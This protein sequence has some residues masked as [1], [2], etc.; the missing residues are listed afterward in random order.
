M[1][2]AEKTQETRTIRPWYRRDPWYDYL[3][4]PL[5]RLETDFESV[6]ERLFGGDK[7]HAPPWSGFVPVANLVE[8]E[9]QYEVAIELPGMQP[10]DVCV[11]LRNGDLWIA[12]EKKEE[13]EEKGKTF[14][15]IERSYGEFRRV[16]PLPGNVIEDKIEAAYKDG[17]LRVT[18]PKSEVIKAKQI[19]IAS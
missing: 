18:L 3:P 15:R 2:T 17:V 8:T 10:A 19:P 5:A 12:G 6:M 14:H 11:E 9:K 1:A 13:Q 7:S 4:R 16:I